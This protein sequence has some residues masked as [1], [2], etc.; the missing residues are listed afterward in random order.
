MSTVVSAEIRSNKSFDLKEDSTVVSSVQRGERSI[1]GTVLFLRK[2]SAS[3][4]IGVGKVV[5]GATS[6][7]DK[8]Y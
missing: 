5:I 4:I 6:L 3:A 1:C 7:R 8:Y 2:Y